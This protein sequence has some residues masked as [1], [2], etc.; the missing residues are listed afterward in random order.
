MA[1]NVAGDRFTVET[2]IP[3]GADP[4]VYEPS[5]QDAARLE[6]S[7]V[8]IVNGAG[9]EAWLEKTMQNLGGNR[10]V[11]IAS[12][13]LKTRT[14][15]EGEL[16]ANS[17]EDPHFWLDPTLAV[18]YVENIRD[19]L[20]KADPSNA[21]LYRNNADAYIVQLKELDTW[22]QAQVQSIPEMRRLLVTNHESL[23]YYADRY[24]LKVIGTLIPSVSSEASPSAQELAHLVDT[25][26]SSGAPAIFLE[27]G[28]NPQLAKQVAAE[29][30]IT[31]VTDLF[32]ESITPANGS[33]PTYLDMLR[34]DTNAVV[35][36]LQ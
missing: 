3:V 8:L 18:H 24:G 26:H 14:A 19:G 23:G 10:L 20:T 9:Y 15:H 28:T 1:Q 35:H 11:V 12:Q 34:H 31:V 13:G 27:A 7:T 17:G 16:A 2:L 6:S 33:A 22:I 25:I 21:D 32:T 5:P 30:G 29:T 36:A 4:H